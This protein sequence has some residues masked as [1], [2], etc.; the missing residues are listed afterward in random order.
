MNRRQMLTLMAAM[1]SQPQLG[2]LVSAGTAKQTALPSRFS[3]SLASL[4]THTLPQWFDD[5]KFGIFIHWGLYSIPAFAPLGANPNPSAPDA[6]RLSPYAEWYEN[7]Q[8]FADSETAIYHRQQYGDAPYSH[9]RAPFEKAAARFSEQQW[10]DVFRASGARY[11]TMVT[12]HHDGYLL[13]PSKHRNPNRADWQSKSD[14]VGRVAN[15]VRA[16]GMRFGAYYSGGLDWTFNTSRLDNGRAMF[17]SMP[18]DEIYDTY[19]RNHYLE[20]IA[21]YRPDYLWND[22]GYPTTESMLAVVSHFYNTNP[23]ALINDRWL[24]ARDFISL[25]PEQQLARF[26][27]YAAYLRDHRPPPPPHY[28]V[29]TPEYATAMKPMEK[30]WET[31]RGI[32]RSFGFNARETEADLMSAEAIVHLLVECVAKG[33]NLLL[34]VGPRG[35][36]SLCP[37][38]VERLRGVGRWLSVNGEAIY[39]TRPW[40]ISETEMA[41]KRKV[42]FTAKGN[43]VYA[44]LLDTKSQ[45]IELGHIPEFAGQQAKRIATSSKYASVYKFSVK[46]RNGS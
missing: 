12:K 37:M 7:T 8:K 13:W 3:A 5:A 42:F 9:F 40:R 28:D 46:P 16:A 11:V 25:P 19:C 31:T 33:G 27:E 26:K 2:Q 22:I 23:D 41:D 6:M 14:I 36:G 24:S 45:L 43:T 21:Q 30:K 18:H 34:N 1:G 10:A 17:L 15:A 39:G 29:I 35:D 20:L 44:T 32:G 38:Q 4:N